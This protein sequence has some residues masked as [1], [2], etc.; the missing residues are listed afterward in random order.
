MLFLHIIKPFF[1]F[2][3][4]LSSLVKSRYF[5]DISWECRRALP[6]ILLI[7]YNILYSLLSIKYIN[8]PF[9]LLLLHRKAF[10]FFNLLK[11]SLFSNLSLIEIFLSGWE[12]KKDP[13]NCI[14]YYLLSIKNIYIPFILLILLII[15]TFSYFNLHSSPLS[16][17]SNLRLEIVKRRYFSDI[18]WVIPRKILPNCILYTK[19][20]CLL[21]ITYIY[22]LNTFSFF[23]LHSPPF[24]FLFNLRLQIVE[25]RYFYDISWELRKLLY[26]LLS[27]KLHLNYNLY[28]K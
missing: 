20:Y 8:I 19:L 6:N 13:S 9:I 22:I 26:S 7:T 24:S 12:W 28:T 11:S 17:L 25:R 5:N 15:I 23:N 18:S 21:S 10:F 14:L 1:I 27:I 4:H 16:F 3:S 2:K